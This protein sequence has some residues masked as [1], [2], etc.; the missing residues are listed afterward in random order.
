[1][2][3]WIVAAALSLS[4][5]AAG[6]HPALAEI[7]AM[8]QA[9]STAECSD[10]TY[11]NS[12][13]SGTCSHHGGVKRWLNGTPTAS[14]GPTANADQGGS[15]VGTTTLAGFSDGGN[16]G[17]MGGG[18][19]VSGGSGADNGREAVTMPRT[20]GAPLLSSLCGLMLAGGAF[21]LRRRIR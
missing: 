3:R 7:T 21:G 20:G 12:T 1:M 10:G 16:G 5:L 8:R 9:D 15:T 4:L 19:G 18:S 11:S 17:N 6:L 13:G 2:K 14:A